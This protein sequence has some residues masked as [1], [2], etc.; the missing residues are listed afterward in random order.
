MNK[1]TISLVVVAL[2]FFI[3]ALLFSTTF[4]VNAASAS[5]DSISINTT[6]NSDQKTDGGNLGSRRISEG[7]NQITYTYENEDGENETS[8]YNV[9]VDNLRYIKNANYFFGKSKTHSNI[10]GESPLGL[11]STVALP[12]LLVP[13]LLLRQTY[14]PR[15]YKCWSAIPV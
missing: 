15:S 6:T 1:K 10:A 8:T 14:A 13:Q 3:F 4:S 7:I 11:C 2:S 5:T 12:I 9:T